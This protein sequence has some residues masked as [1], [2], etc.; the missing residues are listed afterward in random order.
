LTKIAIDPEGEYFG[1][2]YPC[3]ADYPVEEIEE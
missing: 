3:K 1:S 2:I